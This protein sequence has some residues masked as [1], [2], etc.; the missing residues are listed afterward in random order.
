M[1][2]RSAHA[3]FRRALDRRNLA[4]ALAAAHDL[5]VI[6]LG[7]ALELCLLMLEKD[8]RLYSQASARWLGRWCLEVRETTLAD[9]VLIVGAL[10]ALS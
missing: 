2:A 10:A 5:P 4:S 6:G 3:Q 9:A 1:S 7:D 8:R